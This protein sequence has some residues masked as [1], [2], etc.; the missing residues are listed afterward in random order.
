MIRFSVTWKLFIVYILFWLAIVFLASCGTRNVGSN[1][2][3]YNQYSST[4]NE[5]SGSREIK[6]N[7]SINSTVLQNN[8]KTNESQSKKITEI[9]YQ[10][11]GLQQRITEMLDNKSIDKSTTITNTITKFTTRYVEK[12]KTLEITKNEITT[13]HKTKTVYRDSTWVANLG[14]PLVLIGIAALIIGAIFAFKWFK[15]P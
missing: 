15:K 11:G 14:G 4:Q 9:F 12:W 10:G 6:S 2:D 3:K 8:D 13:L 5:T 7:V 1:T